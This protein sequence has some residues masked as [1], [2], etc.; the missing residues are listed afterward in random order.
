VQ[1]SQKIACNQLY[2]FIISAHHHASPEKHIQHI[3]LRHEDYER[4]PSCYCYD[5]Y[6]YH[7]YGVTRLHL[8]T[9]AILGLCPSPGERTH[10]RQFNGRQTIRK[11]IFS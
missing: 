7:H 9:P 5:Y 4:L 1:K 10:D 3:A 2:H 6:F 11:Q 8:Y